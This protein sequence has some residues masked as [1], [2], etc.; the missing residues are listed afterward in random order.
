MKMVKRTMPTSSVAIRRTTKKSTLKTP[1]II[2]T[3]NR[4]RKAQTVGAENIKRSKTTAYMKVLNLD[5]RATDL[6]HQK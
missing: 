3:Q 5:A 1:S 4:F 6:R 2:Q